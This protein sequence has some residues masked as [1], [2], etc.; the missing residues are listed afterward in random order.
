MNKCTAD[1]LIGDDEL[2]ARR[3]ELA[4]Q[5]GFASPESPWQQYFRE[6]VQPFSEGMVLRDAPDY[7]QLPAPKGCRG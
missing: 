1:I 3:D 4:A 5:G 6:M 7:S 2:V